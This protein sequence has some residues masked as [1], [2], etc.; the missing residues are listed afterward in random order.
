MILHVYSRLLF[1][2]NIIIT[3]IE[4]VINRNFAIWVIGSY[5][6]AIICFAPSQVHL[7]GLNL[8]LSDYFTLLWIFVL[9][10]SKNY[11]RTNIKY[12][13]LELYL[14]FFF[15]MYAAV[16]TIHGMYEMKSLS[17]YLQLI[18]NFFILIIIIYFLQKT[19]I[20]KINKFV[21]RFAFVMSVAMLGLYIL[22]LKT[23][24]LPINIFEY[25]EFKSIRFEGLAGDANFY[26]LLMTVAFLIGYYSKPKDLNVRFK[27]IYLLPI[28]LNI[29]MTVSR[30]VIVTLI[31]TFIFLSFIFEKKISRKLKMLFI[32]LVFLTIFIYLATIP[33]PGLDI[34]IY[35]WYALR[36][37][38]SSPRFEMWMTLLDYF[39]INPFFGYGLRA[40]EMLLGGAG[41]YA[42]SSYIEL[43]IDYGIVGFI[44]FICF[45]FL[46]LFK[47]IELVKLNDSYKAWLHSYLMTCLLFAG[48]T[49][50]YWPFLWVIFSIILGGFIYEK[51][52]FNNNII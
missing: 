20:L 3:K 22:F 8:S 45:M 29:V 51:N 31:V 10:A 48:F 47:G 23:G 13:K 33:L 30:S 39:Q 9:V 18:K 32:F 40:S 38:Q 19:T 4:G 46:V 37:T 1:I 52:R 6:I 21:F 7:F 11:L 36:L 34:S 49:F 24:M 44:I 50:L 43:L 16:Q 27:I 14:L 12:I 26:G 17:L 35:E 28:G 41:N 2:I 5:Y 15:I 25:G 42:H